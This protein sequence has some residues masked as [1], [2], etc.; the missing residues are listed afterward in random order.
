[1]REIKFR[2]LSNSKRWV[3][4]SLVY[5]ENIQPAIYFE[6]GKGSVKSFDWVYVDKETIGQFTGLTDRNGVKIFEG[7]IIDIY[8]TPNQVVRNC[9]VYFSGGGFRSKMEGKFTQFY[10]RFTYLYDNEIPIEVKGNIF[11]NKELI[12][13]KY[14]RNRINLPGEERAN[15]KD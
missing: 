1:M 8:P 11:E 13:K 2:G 6:V 15:R 14:D 5:S 9:I 12:E 4:G 7:D 3:F 10:E